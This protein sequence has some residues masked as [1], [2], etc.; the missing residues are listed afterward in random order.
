MTEEALAKD[1][2]MLIYAR[3]LVEDKDDLPITLVHNQFIKDPNNP[4]VRKVSAT[5]QA[6]DVLDNWA[7]LEQI[8]KEILDLKKTFHASGGK[9]GYN[10]TD[11]EVGTA[12]ACRAY[13]G[14]PFA[15]ICSG[16]ETIPEYIRRIS[17]LNKVKENGTMGLFSDLKNGSAC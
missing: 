3:A 10:F 2:Q 6:T 13:G 5:V 9:R 1:V 11:I 17:R 4:R 15:G 14:C 8:A 16:R 12:N 7:R